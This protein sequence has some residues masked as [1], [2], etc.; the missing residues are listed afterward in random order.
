MGK[1]RLLYTIVD[2]QKWCAV[3]VDKMNQAQVQIQ[4][5][6]PK[7][8]MLRNATPTWLVALGPM[9]QMRVRQE[10]RI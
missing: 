7:T 10:Q 8:L 6:E 4:I 2:R 9:N 5:S 1:Y 3:L